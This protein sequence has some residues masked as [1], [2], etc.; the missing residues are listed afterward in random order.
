MEHEQDQVRAWKDVDTRAG[1]DH[2]AGEMKVPHRLSGSRAAILAGYVG[3]LAVTTNAVPT[4]PQTTS[5]CCG[6][7]C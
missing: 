2:P 4:I 6:W 7:V 3:V 1:G 5:V